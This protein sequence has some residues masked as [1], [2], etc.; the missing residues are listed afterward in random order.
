MTAWAP[1][2]GWLEVGRIVQGASGGALLPVTLALAADL[3]S[4]RSRARVLGGVGAAQELGSVV[5]PL[6]GVWIASQFGWRTVFWINIP[7]AAAAA[8]LVHQ[9]VPARARTVT[10][11]GTPVPR[12]RVDVVGGL[13]AA[14]S[15]GV[16]VVALNN[17]HPEISVLPPHGRLL[18]GI[19]AALFAAFIGWEIVARTKLLD[20]SN[21]AKRPFLA[22]ILT[23]LCAGAALLVTLFFVQ[24]DAQ[25]VL[26]KSAS[27]AALLLARFLIAL[28][29]GAV[30][31]GFLVR[32]LGNR[33]VSVVGL[34]LATG[35]YVLISR[36]PIDFV[37]ATHH[38]AGLHLPVLE[39]DLGLAGLG[40]GLVIAPLSDAVLRAV[41]EESHGIASAALVV[42]RMMGM[43]IGVAALAAW[44]LHKFQE[45]T[46]DLPTPLPF[47]VS[48][49]VYAQQ[50]A[51]Y[52]AKVNGFLLIEYRSIFLIIAVVCAVGA[53][54]ALGVDGGRRVG[55]AV[56]E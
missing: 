48:D 40:L 6:Y 34:V 33:V 54:V 4:E 42:S 53:V 32:R 39:T 28:P 17:Q 49:E 21:V 44:G 47:G 29:V 46:A 41:P 45:L 12:P 50:L 10:P 27:Q 25:S 18:I 30:I 38:I 56:T 9:A 22:A 14:A 52:Q 15:L 51:A 11:D 31:G 55:A 19:S 35:G 20:M 43:L 26:G 2:V 13:L 3:W 1:T 37:S 24:L 8:L 36:W 5:G 23:S 16:L 7:L